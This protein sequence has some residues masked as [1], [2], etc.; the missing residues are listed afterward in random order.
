[1]RWLAVLAE[2]HSHRAGTALRCAYVCGC[3]EGA[4]DE[5]EAAGEGGEEAE[6][7][8][9]NA[10]DGSVAFGSAGDGWAFTLG[11]FAEM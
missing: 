6:V 10:V 11:Q 5:G 4:D 9:F 3:R 8:T 2:A 1:M 7:D